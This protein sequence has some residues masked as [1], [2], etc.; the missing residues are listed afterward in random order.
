MCLGTSHD[1]QP[2][3]GGEIAIVEKPEPGA[4][5]QTQDLN[6]GLPMNSLLDEIIIPQPGAEGCNVSMRQAKA[7]RS[8]V[9]EQSGP[10]RASKQANQPHSH[11]DRA[12]H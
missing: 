4:N 9:L 12:C 6:S 10:H 7:R 5:L 11:S 3:T 2:S 1:S 8:Q